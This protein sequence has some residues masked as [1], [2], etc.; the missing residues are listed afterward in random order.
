MISGRIQGNVGGDSSVELVESSLAGKHIK[1]PVPTAYL[2]KKIEVY[3]TA[4]PG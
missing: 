4:N 1:Q 3:K 2:I